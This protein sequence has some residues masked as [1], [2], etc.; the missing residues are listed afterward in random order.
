M[1][2]KKVI[3]KQRRKKKRIGGKKI[4]WSQMAEIEICLRVSINL[5]GRQV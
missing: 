2:R 3:K 5:Q 4:S 1:E